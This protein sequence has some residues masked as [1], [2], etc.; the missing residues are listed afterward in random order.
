MGLFNRKPKGNTITFAI[1]GMHCTSCTMAID[2]ELED[3]DGVLRSAT[4]YAKGETVVEY[5]P[6]KVQAGAFETVIKKLG[7]TPTKKA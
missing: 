7:Y 4:N 1:E 3:L 2:G 6:A 5:D